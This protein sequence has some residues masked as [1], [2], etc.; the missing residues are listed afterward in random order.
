[1]LEIKTI[2]NGE[3]FENCYLLE[4]EGKAVC[5]DPG[6]AAEEV[7]AYLDEKGA[8]LKYILLTHGHFDHVASASLLR[9][10]TGAI[11]LCSEKET[12][13]LLNPD[14]NMGSSYNENI[15]I[16]PDGTFSDGEEINIFK[17]PISFMLTP[18]HTAGSAVIICG[19]DMFSGDTL[20]ADCFGRTDLPTGSSSEM[21]RSL[22]KLKR[23]EKNYRVYAGHGPR[24]TLHG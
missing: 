11:L 13:L 18:G 22:K 9:E 2:V 5:I 15:S 4:E 6:Y 20:F 7:L 23:L 17:T 14:M 8:T 19:D 1:M 24:S 10:R 21:F 3:L 16:V 12:E